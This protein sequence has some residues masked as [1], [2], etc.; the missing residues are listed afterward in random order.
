LIPRPAQQLVVRHYHGA[1]DKQS[2]FGEF[3]GNAVAGCAKTG[4]NKRKY[5]SLR[6]DDFSGAEIRDFHR[7]NS[8]IAAAVSVMASANKMRSTREGRLGSARFSN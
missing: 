6:E 4:D 5:I 3:A 2:P 1:V 7:K 8:S